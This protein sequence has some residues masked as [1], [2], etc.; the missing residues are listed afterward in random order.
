MCVNCA[1]LP[2]E[3]FE[4]ELFGHERGAFTGA[5]RSRAGLLQDSDGGTVFLD[6]VGELSLFAQAKLLRVMRIRKFSVSATHDRAPWTSGFWQLR[7]AISRGWWTKASSG[8]ISS[9]V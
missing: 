7:I 6:E 1:A 4:S 3:L 9:I 8:G 5:Y 2:E